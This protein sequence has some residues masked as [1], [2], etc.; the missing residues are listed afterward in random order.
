[1][2]H[3][4]IVNPNPHAWLID[5]LAGEDAV[6]RTCRGTGRIAVG[7]NRGE[8]FTCPACRGTGRT[9]GPR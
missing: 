1:M 9:G 3:A 4:P 6:C 5:A 2:T 8:N 7:A